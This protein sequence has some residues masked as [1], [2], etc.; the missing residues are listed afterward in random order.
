MNDLYNQLEHKLEKLERDYSTGGLGFHCNI[1]RF[2]IPYGTDPEQIGEFFARVSDATE[3]FAVW[4]SNQQ[5]DITDL[6][7]MDEDGI[8]SEIV[9]RIEC[10]DGEAEIYEVEFE[11]AGEEKILDTSEKGDE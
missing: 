1:E 8:E 2:G 11:I 10:R 3:P 9:Y 4:H 5:H 7:E 6:H